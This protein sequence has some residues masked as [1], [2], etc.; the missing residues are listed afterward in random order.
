MQDGVRIVVGRHGRTLIYFG[1]KK[2]NTHTEKIT[3]LF[4]LK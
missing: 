3:N 2:K 1:K 4:K